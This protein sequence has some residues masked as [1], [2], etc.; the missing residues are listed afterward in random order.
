MQTPFNNQIGVGAF[1]YDRWHL[2]LIRARVVEHSEYIRYGNTLIDKS[3]QCEQ[4]ETNMTG[5]VAREP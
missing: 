3:N 5:T 4:R 2:E 1:T